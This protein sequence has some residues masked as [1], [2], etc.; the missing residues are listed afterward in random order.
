MKTLRVALAPFLFIVLTAASALAQVPADVVAKVDALFAKWNSPDAPGV[1][2]AVSQNG[3][4][5]LT[6]A[7]GRADLEH[8]LPNTDTTL[9]ESGS[10]SKQFTAAAVVLLA[11]Q[12]KLALSDDLR[13]HIPE[14]PDYGTP[15]TL[16]HLLNHTSGLRDW[17]S[18][19]SI[20]G[21]PR[22]LRSH[23]QDHVIDI[24]RRQR[25]LNYTPGDRYSYTN[26]GYNLLAI[27]VTRVSGMPFAEFCRVNL[28]EPLGLKHT[29]WRDDHTR[30]VKNRATAYSTRSD[31]SYAI[32]Q[33]IED[34][35][36]NG[37]LIT[38]LADLITWNEAIAANKLGGPGFTEEMQRNGILNNG[39][40]IDYASGLMVGT[41]RRVPEVAHTGSTS[42]YRA[43]LARYPVQGL[44]IALLAN[45]GNVNPG[46]LGRQ[47]ADIFLGDAV[48]PVPVAAAPEPP[49]PAPTLTAAELAP[50]VGEYHSPDIEL[51]LRITLE[52][53]ELI[54]HRR[55]ATRIVLKPAAADTFTAPG[56]G[57]IRFIR[58]TPGYVTQLSV[59]QERV[60]DLRFER[61]VK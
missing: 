3:K 2:I 22:E 57:R 6:R 27:I 8:D 19:A 26:S 28:F 13:K 25:G 35:H 38:T 33:P 36:G 14:I 44:G 9:F 5:I 61:V 16:R 18:L 12:G 32:D 1:V 41:H 47:V 45:A 48:G 50:L 30:I 39:N 29:Q 51:T 24:L 58:D 4:I 43:F 21:W 53:G 54:A 7:Y 23:S 34:V 31:G 55:P 17:G 60:Y 37:G 59:Q 40:K 46:A 11:Q 10:V 20:A 56:L 52:N 42:G 15:I 49:P